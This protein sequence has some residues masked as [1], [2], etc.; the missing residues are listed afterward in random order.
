MTGANQ[1]IPHATPRPPCK[2]LYTSM[3]IQ[4]A[5]L[6]QWVQDLG[7]GKSRLISL[8]P[9]LLLRCFPTDLMTPRTTAPPFMSTEM[10][11]KLRG[12]GCSSIRVFGIRGF[13]TDPRVAS[14]SLR[15]MRGDTSKTTSPSA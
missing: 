3:Q 9:T 6:S 8:M 7:E 2:L 10:R 13:N 5:M 1:V 12:P 11:Q 4:G 14:L 15:L